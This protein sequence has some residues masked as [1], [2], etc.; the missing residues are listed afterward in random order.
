M[1]KYTSSSF[2][3]LLLVVVVSLGLLSNTIV[4]ASRFRYGTLSW[5]PTSTVDV[6][7]DL[8]TVEFTIR[9]SFRRDYQWGAYFGE[10]WAQSTVGGAKVFYGSEGLLKEGSA[11]YDTSLPGCTTEALSN[12][13]TQKACFNCPANTTTGYFGCEKVLPEYDILS[14]DSSSN[15]IVGEKF[16]IRFPPKK[17]NDGVT[18]IVPCPSPFHCDVAKAEIDAI[19]K[20]ATFTSASNTVASALCGDYGNNPGKESG[21]CAPWSEMY[22]MFMGDGTSKTVELEVTDM[23]KTSSRLGNYLT[24]VGTFTHAYKRGT[25]DPFVAYFTGGERMYECNYPH[26]PLSANGVCDGSLNVLMN[27]NQQ[28]RYRL[29]VEVWLKG[30]GNRSPVVHQIPVIPIP[31]QLPGTRAKFQI[32]A[33]DPDGDDLVFR[34]GNSFEMGGVVRSKS[35]AYPFSANTALTG[36]ARTNYDQNGKINANLG[37]E[38]GPYECNIASKSFALTGRCASDRE[39]S[40]VSGL[41]SHSFTS[42]VPGLVEWNTW[43]AIDGNACPNADGTGCSKLRSGFYNMVVMVSDKSDKRTSGV[44]VPVDFLAYLYDGPMSFCGKNCQANAPGIP[45][46]ADLDGLYGVQSCTICGYGEGNATASQCTPVSA[47]GECG[48]TQSTW[49]SHDQVLETSIVP[50]PNSACKTN[51]PP[52]FVTTGLVNGILNNPRLDM[53]EDAVN[54]V[55]QQKP[56]VTKYLGEAFEFYVTAMDT[57]DCADLVVGAI[58][59]PVGA[60]LSPYEVLSDYENNNLG[61]KVR[62]KFTWKWENTEGKSVSEDP[63]PRESMVCFYASDNYLITAEPYYCIEL[64]LKTKPVKEE[65][66]LLRFNC[67]LALNWQPVLKRFVVVDGSSKYFTAMSYDDYMWHHAMVSIDHEGLGKLYV[68]GAEQELQ[69]HVGVDPSDTATYNIGTSVGDFFHAVE[70]PNNCEDTTSR[71]RLQYNPAWIASATSGNVSPDSSLDAAGQS[72]CSFRMG[73]ACEDGSTNYFDGLV[74]EIAVWNRGLDRDEISTTLFHMPKSAAARKLEAPRGDQVDFSAGRSLYSRFNNPCVEGPAAGISTKVSDDAGYTAYID[75]DADLPDDGTTIDT[76]NGKYVYTGVPWSTPFVTHTTVDDSSLPI[77]GGITIL[78]YGVGFAKSPFMKCVSGIEMENSI[79]YGKYEYGYKNEPGTSI[80]SNDELANVMISSATVSHQPNDQLPYLVVESSRHPASKTYQGL[81]RSDWFVT[82]ADKATTSGGPLRFGNIPPFQT[83]PNHSWLPGDNLRNSF[84]Y[85]FYEVSMCQLPSGIHPAESYYLGVS[86]DGAISSSP[87]HKNMTYSEF[88]MKTSATS[89]VQL[90]SEAKGNTFAMWFMPMSAGD[91]TI[92]LLSNNL[93]VLWQNSAVKLMDSSAQLATSE[94]LALNEWHH[95]TIVISNDNVLLFVDGEQSAPSPVASVIG[96]YGIV[97]LA[98]GFDGYIDELKVLQEIMDPSKIFDVMFTRYA[99]AGDVY[100]RF[101]TNE[102]YTATPLQSAV[103]IV[104]TS[105]PWEPLLVYSTTLDGKPASHLPAIGISMDGGEEIGV[106]GFNIAP[107]KWL[108]CNFG[109]YDPYSVVVNQAGASSSSA[110]PIGQGSLNRPDGRVYTSVQYELNRIDRSSPL[111]TSDIT[112]LSESTFKCSVPKFAAV[113]SGTLGFGE[114]VQNETDVDIMESSLACSG[115]YADGFASASS[116][117]ESNYNGYTISLWAKPSTPGTE[118][119]VL[120]AFQSS[121]TKSSTITYEGMKF[122]YY[123]DKILQVTPQVDSLPNKWHHVAITVSNEGEGNLFINGEVVQT[124]TTTSTPFP[125]NELT[126]CGSLTSSGQGENFFLGSVDHVY[127]FKDALT[128]DEVKML[129][130]PAE[131][132][133][134][135][136]AAQTSKGSDY[137]VGFFTSKT[138]TNFD[139]Q[140]MS[141][142]KTSGYHFMEDSGLATPS[143]PATGQYSGGPI[144]HYNMERLFFD[145]SGKTLLFDGSGNDRTLNDTFTWTD[146]R[147]GN[148]NGAIIVASAASVSDIKLSFT[149]GLSEGTIIVWMRV[150]SWDGYDPRQSSISN[151]GGF[152]M[153]TLTYSSASGNELYINS[154]KATHEE[155]SVFEGPLASAFSKGTLLNG[156]DAV[157]DELWIFDRILPEESISNT[158]KLDDYAVDLSKTPVH[159]LFDTKLD[160]YRK[161]SSTLLFP[162]KLPSINSFEFWL[163]P[164]SFVNGTFL[165]TSNFEVGFSTDEVLDGYFTTTLN[166][167]GSTCTCTSCSAYEEFTSSKARLELNRWTHLA[168]GLSDKTMSIF[169]DG[170]LFDRKTFSTSLDK[171]SLIDDTRMMTVGESFDGLLYDIRLSKESKK[172]SDFRITTQCPRAASSGEAY[173][174]LN[175]GNQF[176]HAAY[177]TLAV[178]VPFDS[179]WVDASYDDDTFL[180]Y[181]SFYDPI[182]SPGILTVAAK[183]ACMKKRKSGG[184]NFV[185]QFTNVKDGAKTSISASDSGDGNYYVSYLGLQCGTY[186][187]SVTSNSTLV[188]GFNVEIPPN[189]TSLT[190]SSIADMNSIAS[191]NV[192]GCFGSASKIYIQSMDDYGC[193]SGLDGSDSWTATFTGPDDFTVK[194]VHTIDGLYEISFVPPAAGKYTVQIKLGEAV[195]NSFCVDVCKGNAMYFYGNTAVEYADD[196]ET[197]SLEGN[198]GLTMEAWVKPLSDSGKD[199]YLLLKDSYLN[200][201]KFTKGYELVLLD[202]LST[203]SAS[204]YV[205]LGEVRTISAPITFGINSWTHLCI[206]YTGIEMN[207][208]VNG[209]LKASKPFSDNKSVHVNPYSHPLTIGHG[210]SGLMDEVKIFSYGKLPSQVQESMYCP[211][212]LEKEKLVFHLG[213]NNA[214]EK[215]TPTALTYKNGLVGVKGIGV[216]PIPIG[217]FTTVDNPYA[218]TTSQGVGVA[219]A[220]YTTANVSSTANP[221]GL[222]AM[223]VDVKDK[224]GFKYTGTNAQAISVVFNTFTEKYVKMEPAHEIGN[225]IAGMSYPNIDL[226][227]GTGKGT[228]IVSGQLSDASNYSV[229]VSV[230]TTGETISTEVAAV[231][232]IDVRAGKFSQLQIVKPALANFTAGVASFLRI[233]P[234]DVYGNTMEDLTSIVAKLSVDAETSKKGFFEFFAE[235]DTFGLNLLFGTPGTHNITIVAETF[236]ET[237]TYTF[238]LVVEESPW[239]PLLTKTEELYESDRFGHSAVSYK[240]DMYIFGGATLDKTYRSD[241]SKLNGLDDVASLQNS[242]SYKRT[243]TVSGVQSATS[244]SDAVLELTLNTLELV[245]M[246]RMKLSC[247]DIAFTLPSNGQALYHYIHPAPGCI[248]E[249]TKIY[250]RIPHGTSTST[251]EMYYDNSGMDSNALEDGFVVFDFFE[252]FEGSSHQF[253][254]KDACSLENAATQS[255]SPSEDLASY[256][257]STDEEDLPELGGVLSISKGSSVLL[258]ASA[259]KKLTSY[260]LTAT[261]YDAHSPTASYW[262]SPSYQGCTMDFVGVGVHTLSHGSKYCTAS[263]WRATSMARKQGGRLVE[264]IGTENSTTIMIDGVAVRQDGVGSEFEG[265]TLSSG[266]GLLSGAYKGSD[267]IT[268]TYVAFDDISV[269][270]YSGTLAKVTSSGTSSDELV[271]RHVLDRSWSQV[272]TGGSPTPRASHEGALINDIYYIFGGERS[273]YSYKDVWAYDF[274][275]SAWSFVPVTTASPPA[276][277]DHALVS[278]GESMLIAVGG[279]DSSGNTLKDMWALDLVTK[280]WSNVGEITSPAFDLAAASVGGDI[281]V[282]GGYSDQGGLSGTFTK[283]VAQYGDRNV[284]TFACSDITLGCPLLSGQ[285]LA[286]VG[287]SARYKHSMLAYGE[288]DIYVYGGVDTLGDGANMS[289]VEKLYKFDTQTCSWSVANDNLCGEQKSVSCVPYEGIAGVIRDEASNNELG[290]FYHG[291]QTTYTLLP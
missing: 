88:S 212:F 266:Y 264:I 160:S 209:V 116:V 100:F 171:F 124:F 41:S 90:M 53:Y 214:N 93:A 118:Q 1:S 228:Y 242:F 109:S 280:A 79:S 245:G 169:L 176:E 23:D 238:E 59:L 188:K 271:S 175:S 243:L 17:Q 197:F 288:S 254:V 179:A 84:I 277:Y 249:G 267:D 158:Y 142:V 98:N 37:I 231:H 256:V 72:C 95:V 185:A 54:G 232:E 265:V 137:V 262:I 268:N 289:G 226:T 153:Y 127:V 91:A 11:G 8:Q 194:G 141:E 58:N 69:I 71:R 27:N 13:F 47:D 173:F 114:I 135:V 49:N 215:Q 122:S 7:N 201:E 190:A 2:A 104:P 19:T 18:D 279:R 274:A 30:D 110:S 70:Y 31:H 12:V 89:S 26:T 33:N 191:P 198:T 5:V 285:T 172:P 240:G 246:G 154:M 233:N 162:D 94:A 170:I 125:N 182:T 99:Q 157:V 163:K 44:K 229:S 235:G 55:A 46:H 146:D 149:S 24:G 105:V 111:A 25:D 117:L 203:I 21:K 74:D 200:K 133:E 139:V 51:T 269:M 138:N 227:C 260:K 180:G 211:P 210:L 276:R 241:M 43:T 102:G 283:C 140:S 159:I 22:G 132:A 255:L 130:G 97:N 115:G 28:G 219:G 189:A 206:V 195:F 77:D 223:E 128:I 272:A 253:K 259:T 82:D 10:Q 186:Q 174:P 143:A 164:R 166:A 108:K 178:Q 263:P 213:F 16:Y 222:F 147:D 230:I 261:M 150:S 29:E 148:P 284:L 73:Q 83:M 6:A 96:G 278:F 225:A 50:N 165:K 52:K 134:Q 221:A 250:I 131:D 136:V 177:T 62:R 39:P 60:T 273:G 129:S 155:A 217:Q 61:K 181:T 290:I 86:N 35:E 144:A 287:F 247:K 161:E 220:A 204:V 66:T 275:T 145:G 251:I 20:K 38:Y 103:S 85:G 76:T 257:A 68:D 63:R 167:S 57:D 291:G 34:F 87:K 205:G 45:T 36:Q 237:T 32:A 208:Y 196:G 199:A 207:V 156:L 239:V 270:P 248:S 42:S 202:S 106:T 168:I 236:P 286:D 244:G 80:I 120:V 65:E 40:Q 282:L 75:S 3:A 216:G 258:H 113:D 234:T 123:D 121:G 14:S 107:S 64:H 184:D 224:C 192:I 119:N 92:M 4:D 101:N 252:N 78:L 112:K 9:T 281:Y 218:S 126:L 193:K 67:K 187:V 15:G 56:A 81:L 152:R 48:L 183:T 151:Y